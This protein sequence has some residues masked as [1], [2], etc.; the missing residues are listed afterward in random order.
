MGIECSARWSDQDYAWASFRIEDV[1]VNAEL[2]DH[3]H[4]RGA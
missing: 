1:V 3:L 4:R 2:G